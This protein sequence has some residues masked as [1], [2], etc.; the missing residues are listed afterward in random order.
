MRQPNV[1]A[2]ATGCEKPRLLVALQAAVSRASLGWATHESA[3]IGRQVYVPF[4]TGRVDCVR[5]D[6]EFAVYG[7]SGDDLKPFITV[8][9]EVRARER[10]HP[11]PGKRTLRHR[12]QPKVLIGR[13]SFGRG[14][15]APVALE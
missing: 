12:L 6:A 7:G 14:H 3:G 13:A 8:G 11:D 15:F 2:V 9:R 1:A 5:E 10:G 4:A